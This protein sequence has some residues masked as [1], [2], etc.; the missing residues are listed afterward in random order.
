M[1]LTDS[2]VRS[3]IRACLLD[4]LKARSQPLMDQLIMQLVVQ[5]ECDPTI[6]EQLMH[7]AFQEAPEDVQAFWNAPCQ[8]GLALCVD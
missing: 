8:C 2:Y 4:M 1:D 6:L 7:E 5:D 3:E